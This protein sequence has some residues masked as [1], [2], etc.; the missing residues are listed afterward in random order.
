MRFPSPT[1][2]SLL[3]AL[4]LIAATGCGEEEDVSPSFED[5]IPVGVELRTERREVRFGDSVELTG[6]LSQGKEAVAGSEVRLEEDPYPFDESWSA[7]ATEATDA[8]GR[9]SFEAE[10][11]FNTVYRAVAESGEALSEERTVYVDPVASV[12]SEA[13][14]ASTRFTTSFRHSAERSLDGAVVFSY[15]GPVIQAQIV[16]SVPFV[17]IEPVKEVKPG[18]STATALL[19]GSP[20][21]LAY[22]VC[23]SYAPS[24]GVG[25]PRAE[26]GRDK[27]PFGG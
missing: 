6:S 4:V 21:D 23:V 9:F 22:D 14:G 18:L 24:N 15:G 20:G 16:G 7:V 11:T 19:P 1:R 8:K 12:E 10:P 25:V 5:R 13:E 26:C 3:P 27:R 17:A 2:L